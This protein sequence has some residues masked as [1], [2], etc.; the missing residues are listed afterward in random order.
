MRNPDSTKNT[1]TPSSPPSTPATPPWYS[2]TAMTAK[3]RMPSSDARRRRPLR[4]GEPVPSPPAPTRS[5][6]TTCEV[7]PTLTVG[8]PRFT[9]PTTILYPTEPPIETTL[10]SGSGV[11]LEW[12]IGE[13]RRLA[14]GHCGRARRSLSCG[15]PKEF[16]FTKNRP[17]TG[18]HPRPETRRIRRDIGPD[19]IRCGSRAAAR[20]RHTHRPTER[21]PA[22]R[23]SSVGLSI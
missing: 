7:S 16:G 21:E 14:T 1:S 12:T 22:P 4:P 20:L 2:S 3:A 8:P 11:Q 5:G 6:G 23:G 18:R 19:E 9:D 10:F 15:R 17:G 13:A